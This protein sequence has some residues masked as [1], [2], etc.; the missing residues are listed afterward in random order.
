MSKT[1]TTSYKPTETYNLLKDLVESNDKI[2]ASGGT[3]VSVSII[4]ER[5]IGKSTIQKELANDLGRYFK[6]VSLAQYTQPEELVG[7]Y[8]KENLV[9]K[10]DVSH[11]VTENLIPKF[12]EDGYEYTSKTRTKPC[13]PDWVMDLQEGA[14]IVL[15]DYSRGNQLF[16]Q[17]IME[18]VNAQ[19]MVGWDLKSKK[20]QIFLNENPDSGE[21]NVSSQ[22]S[23]QTDRMGKIHMIWDAQDWAERAEKIGMNERLINFVLWAPELLENKKQDGI[24]AS[25]SVSPRMMDKFFSLVATI[26]DWEQH[27]DRISTYGDITVGKDVTSQLI[28]F[29]NKKL[30]KLP[31]IGKMIKEDD[32]PTAKTRLTMCCGDCEKDS[33]NWKGATAAILTTR[34]Y[35]Y[36]RYNVKDIK[37]DEIKQYLELILHPSFSVDQKYLMVKQTIKL[38]NTF[39]QVLS[40]DPRFL[41]Y[42]AS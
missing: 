16:S 29:I 40:S 32:L 19:E 10:G 27:L 37:K 30:D 14:I 17:A 35:N 23:A 38:S 39:A 36:M 6:K 9:I 18:L 41:K 25:N 13:P 1:T 31:S 11:W 42:M 3:P 2:I 34:M 21:Y 5:G 24:S 12:I 28:N 20:C 4:G 22:D 7:F 33:N 26:D 15:D 8:Q